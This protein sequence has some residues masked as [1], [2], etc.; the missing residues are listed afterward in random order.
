MKPS[1]PER[2]AKVAP[3]SDKQSSRGPLRSALS[4]G[5][6]AVWGC[7]VWDA[8]RR[9]ETDGDRALVGKVRSLAGGSTG[10]PR[11]LFEDQ[12]GN[13]WVG[14]RGG[15]LLRVSE[16]VVQND[17]ESVTGF[18]ANDLPKYADTSKKA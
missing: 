2:Q 15:G 3:R 18:P 16:S 17:I 11:A 6:V 14:M 4:D 9:A 7:C 5:F 1:E 12:D 10:S 8:W 13:I